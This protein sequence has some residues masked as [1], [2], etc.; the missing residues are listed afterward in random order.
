MLHCIEQA[1]EGGGNQ[2]VDGVNIA[3]QLKRDH[4]ET[5]HTLCTVQIDFRDAGDDH[6][7]YHLKS[8]RPMIQLRLLFLLISSCLF[9][10]PG[11][12]S[13]L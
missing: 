11:V 5:Y 8:R 9:L 12:V 4:P 3:R 13:T 10:L 6:L 2:F 1:G 7:N